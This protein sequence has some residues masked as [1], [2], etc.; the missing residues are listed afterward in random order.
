MRKTQGTVTLLVAALAI[1]AVACAATEEKKDDTTGGD[2]GPTAGFTLYAS[3]ANGLNQHKWN[4]CEVDR[5]IVSSALRLAMTC[6]NMQA[7]ATHDLNL[8]STGVRDATKVTA[9]LKFPGSGVSI[10]S[11]GNVRSAVGLAYQPVAY[12]GVS[13]QDFVEAR[14]EFFQMDGGSPVAIGRVFRCTDA[15]CT[16]GARIDGSRTDGGDANGVITGSLAADTP[17]TASVEYDGSQ[18]ILTFNGVAG[19]WAPPTGFDAAN[20]SHVRLRNRIVSGST[21]GQSGSFTATFDDVVATNA[22]AAEVLNDNFDASANIDTVK[23]ADGD[24]SRHVVNEAL[25]VHQLQANLE[26]TFNTVLANSASIQGLQADVTVTSHFEESSTN[27]A[28]ARIQKSLFNDGTMG[29]GYGGRN[30]DVFAQVFVREQAVMYS[31]FRCIDAAC[32][33][34]AAL[35]QASLGTLGGLNE[36]AKLMLFWDGAKL[37][38]RLNSDPVVTYDPVAEGGMTMANA[39]PAGGHLASIGTRVSNVST[40]EPGLPIP[41]GEY[42]EVTATF[43]NIYV[44]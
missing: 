38:V 31:L 41:A 21:D 34:G 2:T 17:Y 36:L 27:A 6:G 10:P 20:F 7:N 19:T 29:D 30:G 25:V 43:D 44:K 28:V 5:D 16:P 13:S 42:G 23:W 32:S 37:Y 22:S 33:D 26:R 39:T 1:L 24:G 18:F 40:V 4:A 12:R 15:A 8:E 3:F 35:H 11:G 9:T 14:V